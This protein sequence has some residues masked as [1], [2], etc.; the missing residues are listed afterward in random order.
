MQRIHYLLA[1]LLVRLGVI[2]VFM[3]E[4]IEIRVVDKYLRADEIQQREHSFRLF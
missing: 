2:F 3:Q 1:L 4:T